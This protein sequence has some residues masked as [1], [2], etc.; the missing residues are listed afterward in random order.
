MQT[1]CPQCATQFRVT[2]SQI[3]IADGYVRCGVCDKVFNVHEVVDKT[4][5]E[6]DHQPS[7]AGSYH[8]DRHSLMTGSNEPKKDNF[9]FFGNNNNEF[10][11]HVVPEK[12]RESHASNS[13]SAAS[14][15]LWSIGFLLLIATLFIEYIWFNRNQFIQVPEIQAEIKELC[16]TFDCKNLTM[17]APAKIQLATKNIFSHPGEKDIL[18]VKFT[19]KNNASFSQPYPVMSI[20]FS[21]IRGSMVASRYFLPNEYLPLE[22][23]QS[24]NKQQ[25]LLQPDAST[26]VTLEIRDPGTQAI[27]YEFDFL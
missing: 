11:D 15:V 13:P 19:M 1:Q 10:M 9:D 23:Q 22:Y 27:A 8:P 7:L 14:T 26:S 17:R 16:Q 25:S 20:N 18:M 24:N 6:D 12:F 2:E 21:D 4:S 5:P 3:N